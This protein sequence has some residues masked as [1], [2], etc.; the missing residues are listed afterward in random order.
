MERTEADLALFKATFERNGSP[1]TIEHLR[2]QYL[3]NPTGKIFVDLAIPDDDAARAAAI[4]SVMPVKLRLSGDVVL[5]VQSLDT[6]TDAEF[7][8]KGLFVKMAQ[9]VFAR[10]EKDGVACVYGFPN[11]NSAHGFFRRLGWARLDPV[12]F[13]VRPLRANFFLR[14]LGPLGPLAAKLPALPLMPVRR[15]ALPRSQEIR[16]VTQFDAAFDELWNRFAQGIGAAVHR[17]SKY[18]DWR[19][20]KKPGQHYRVLGLYENQRLL[21]FCA[22]DVED[23]HGGR[24]GYILEA[25][26]EPGRNTEATRLIGEA[27]AEM[28]EDGAEV[29]LAWCLPHSPNY[30]AIRKAG[31]ISLPERLRPIE[32]HV[33]VRPLAAPPTANLGNRTNWYLSYL[34]S[35][36]V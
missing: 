9:S 33:G 3:A 31:F 16:P 21:A 12:P 1:R 28:D 4:Y 6:L 27:I 11:G 8:G 19:L 34:D 20:K 29:V 25:I 15:P 26:H 22:F 18:L 24:V 36:T 2:W 13:L 23:K 7:R 17:D 35:D 5:G 30:S 10:C 14:R 32:L